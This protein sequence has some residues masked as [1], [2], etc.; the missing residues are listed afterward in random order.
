MTKHS[1]FPVP[2]V[3]IP[4]GIIFTGILVKLIATGELDREEIGAGVGA[5][6]YGALGF[7]TPPTY[8]QVKAKAK[9][10]VKVI[11]GTGKRKR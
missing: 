11:P 7:A 5:L 3:L 4:A 2:K 10:A 8:D 9:K 1:L 6:I